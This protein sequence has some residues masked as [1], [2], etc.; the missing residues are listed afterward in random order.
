MSN[1][2]EKRTTEYLRDNT[3][4]LSAVT[5]DPLTIFYID[6]AKTDKLFDRLC[7]VIG[8]P[9]S[10][11]TTIANLIQY[12]TIQT[13]IGSAHHSN[14]KFL[15]NALNQ[16]RI[17][18]K[19]KARVISC[20]LPM[21][22]D[23]RE[24]YE[25]PYSDPI[26]SQ[27]LKTFLQ[28]RAVIAWLRSI[29]N[30]EEEKLS[31]V[32]IEFRSGADVAKKSLGGSEA[33]DI[34][35][36]AK[37][38][39]K[40]I[41]NIIA[42]LVPPKIDDFNSVIVDP[43]RPFESIQNIILKDQDGTERKLLPLVILDDVHVLHPDQLGELTSWLSKREMKI[44]RW[45]QMRLDAQTPSAVLSKEGFEQLAGANGERIN[46]EREITYIQL[47]KEESRANNKKL[48]RRMAINMANRYIGLM[49]IF[50]NRG[51][52]SL[53]D[54]LLVTPKSI[55]VS[56]INKLETKI[57][58]LMKKENINN[59]VKNDLLKK[60][61]TY[62][63]AIPS[64][65]GGRDVELAT[66]LILLNRYIK[67][68]PQASLFDSEEFIEPKKEIN[69][70]SD[71]VDGAKIQLMH[72]YKRPYYYGINSLCDSSSENAEQFLHLASRLVSAAETNLI[73][74]NRPELKADYQH[75]LL[76]KKANDIVNNWSF[77]FHSEVKKL[78]D[79]IGLACVSK[80]LEPNAPLGG[81]A[82]AIGIL[83]VEFDTINDKFPNLARVLKFGIAYS[84]LTIKRRHSTKNKYWTLIELSGPVLITKK[85]TLTKGGFLEWSIN[86]LSD[87]LKGQEH[88]IN[89]R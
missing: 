72:L 6:H 41:Y 76:S 4:F 86:E 43:Y 58:N 68:V 85:L 33:Q 15:H 80:S 11:K 26:K 52:N 19:N 47:Q 83:D 74:Q 14:Y 48:F 13:L 65:S 31:N 75:K 28:S 87:K 37:K 59:K 29:E 55:S 57:D 10:G 77:P 5:P 20:R 27:L 1:L 32:H 54:L 53:S 62:F 45:M 64:S 79:E 24:I 60:V 25:L 66:L 7:I 88:G 46:I 35:N 61:S 49:P 69:V 73:T 84:A 18:E 23:Y 3:A 70:K 56:N 40:E 8:T 50:Q 30:T 12:E 36:R 22:S 34:L 78:C 16:C 42:A 21:E 63:G 82:N 2:F 17:I 9:G 71:V 51:L 67:R 39:E 38:I 89:Q 81:G 44:S